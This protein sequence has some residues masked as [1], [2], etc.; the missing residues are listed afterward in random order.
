MSEP[1]FQNRRR[2]QRVLLQVAILIRTE[3]ADGKRV[4][5][6]AFTQEINAHGGL[7]ESSV[8]LSPSLK[9]T[10]VNPQT[11]KEIGCRVVRTEGRPESSFAIAIEF[12]QPSPQFWGVA[13]PPKD[14]G[15]TDDAAAGKTAS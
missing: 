11:Q 8:K 2:S 4:Q 10:L 5:I 12:D 7:L 14:W 9:I 15:I 6:Q 13:F 1:N 3:L